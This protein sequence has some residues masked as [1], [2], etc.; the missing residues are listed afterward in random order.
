V[1]EALIQIIWT[2]DF[3][4]L[5]LPYEVPSLR[6]GQLYIPTLELIACALAVLFA[7][8]AWAVL[9][10]TYFGKA[11]RAAA[12]DPAIAASF[13]INHRVNALL[14]AG[15]CA[16]SAALAGVFIALTTTLAPSQIFSW[17]GVV[18]AV[19]IIGG[20]GNPLGALIAGVLIGVAESMTMAV[21]AP[22]WAPLVAFSLL[23]ALMIWQPRWL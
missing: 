10:W 9:R 2:A 21:T 3:R 14:I 11:V 6:L 22:A 13:G 23:I 5:E 19:V 8:L 18:F 20:L 15:I 1:I 12:E 17:F 4:K 7:V 16:A